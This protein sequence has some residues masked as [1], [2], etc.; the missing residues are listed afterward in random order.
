MGMIES[1]R[2]SVIEME[3]ERAAE[4][5]QKALGE[6]LDAEDI[7]NGA[8]ISALDVV[9]EEYG[10]GKRYL[11]EMLVSAEAMKSAME[12]LSPWLDRSRE[13]LAG[14]VVIGTVE[15]DLHDIGKNVVRMMLEGAG[16][17]VHDL[18]VETPS[19]RFVEAV[20]EYDPDLVGI[21][22]LLTTTMVEIPK[23]L[24][25]LEEN[26]LRDRVK[27]MIGGA[28]VTQ[29]YADEIGADGY[30]QDAAMAVKLAKQLIA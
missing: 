11:P 16:F 21:S 4:L 27:V 24:Q 15:G 12:V 2:Q 19:S 20:K 28:P 5:T 26:E 29:E 14:V 23:V 17:E 8:L 18:G 9:G 30:G 3:V 7:L 10:Q 22:A 25:A 13:K 1:L 6:G